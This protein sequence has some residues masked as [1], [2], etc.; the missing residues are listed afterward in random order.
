MHARKLFRQKRS[1]ARM[2][3]DERRQVA[4]LH[5][6]YLYFGSMKGA[7][8]FQNLVLEKPERLDRA[9]QAIPLHGEVTHR[10]FR[11]F[12]SRPQS[13]IAIATATRLLAMKRQDR[14]L[15]VDSRNTAELARAFGATRASLQTFEGYWKLLKRVWAC[16]WFRAPR[17]RTGFG[18]DLW[19][20][21]VAILDAFYYEP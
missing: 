2:T 3:R 7:G 16:P 12:V 8:A 20:S 14:L 19:D 5:D 1:L 11:A 18:T 15:C 6:D 17:P 10:Q 13:R 21:R 9:L 4:G